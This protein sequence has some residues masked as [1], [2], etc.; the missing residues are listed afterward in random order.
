MADDK[1]QAFPQGAAEDTE[2]PKTEAIPEEDELSLSITVDDGLR[3]IP[4]KNKLGQQIGVF[5][6]RPTD[7]D[8]ISRFNEMT[9]RWDDE[10]TKPLEALGDMPDITAP[11]VE[12]EMRKIKEKLFKLCDY[13]FGGNMSEAFFGSMNPFSPVDGGLYCE[14]AMEA[15]GAFLSEQF[16]RETAKIH[17]RVAKY[18]PTTRDHLKKGGKRRS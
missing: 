2:E 12:A 14:N 7:F 10:V 15:V 3:M 9:R 18:M 6:F 1:T 8:M 17:K 4:V 5:A 13:A 16:D 11:E